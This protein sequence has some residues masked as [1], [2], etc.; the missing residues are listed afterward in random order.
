MARN[1]ASANGPEPLSV[2]QLWQVPVFLL[3][4]VAV[5]AFVMARSLWLDPAAAAA[6]SVLAEA[7]R[8]LHRPNG[9]VDRVVTLAR[10]YLERTGADAPQSGEAHFLIGSALLRTA[11]KANGKEADTCWR[12]VRDHLEEAAQLG[13]SP[14]DQPLLCFR[15]GL[16]GLQTGMDL[17]RVAQLLAGSIEESDEKVEGYRALAH[18][19]LS[20]SP[21]DLG[22]AL[23]ANEELRQLPL[24][25]E[26]ILGPARV[27][28]GDILLRLHRL[29]DARKVLDKVSHTAP[30]SLLAETRVLRAKSY[31]EERNW[32]E[33]APLWREVLAD[34]HSPPT[35]PGPV[36]YQL[37]LCYRRLEQNAD[38][39]RVWRE[40]LQ[41]GPTGTVSSQ[42][43]AVAAALGLADVLLAEADPAA[44]D[45]LERGVHNLRRPED[46]KNSFLCLKKAQA[47]FEH[48]QA[49]YRDK[50]DFEHAV[51]VAELYERLA[52]PAQ[53]ALLLGQGAEGWA[54][55]LRQ[56]GSQEEARAIALFRRA[57]GAYARAADQ[58]KTPREQSE[59]LWL[60]AGA[61]LRAQD[62]ER[63]LPV[64]RRFLD[65]GQHPD[66]TGEAWYLLAEAQRW[67]K[68]AAA[69]EAAYNE[70]VKY[71]GRF[72]HRA[73]YRL[74]QI[75]LQRHPPQVD[76]AV[77]IL[78]QNIR[79]LQRNPDAEAL[80]K[81]LFAL[82]GLLY[83]RHDYQTAQKL[84]EDAVTQFPNSPQVQRGR[85]ELAECW[86]NLAA[87]LNETLGGSMS[88]EARQHYEK[89]QRDWLERAAKQY[90]LLG[91][92]LSA[93]KV[94]TP[95]EQVQALFSIAECRFN[96]G[97]YDAARQLYDQLA[98]RFKGRAEQLN[99]LGGSV[100]CYAAQNQ[101]EKLA[102]RLQ[103]I[104]LVLK[105]ADE[106][107]RHRWEEWLKL[108][109][110]H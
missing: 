84:L 89:Q 54:Q 23:K 2:R 39:A 32:A 8:I 3:G 87:Q 77:E 64:L 30:A 68:N 98:E 86:R 20:L 14:K 59:R 101:A 35:E 81:S 41:R 34:R 36:L 82:G 55:A 26:D 58:A 74:S 18:A 97:E 6:R 63:A 40:C 78:D 29:A 91:T 15:L 9:D 1:S 43:A 4:I 48:G 49:V 60:S 25:G 70:C 16:A 67:L 108:A 50:G 5:G 99:A 31:Q 13:V 72:G 76:R 12:Q 38:A 83:R 46:W 65:L 28:A 22:A 56:R 21:P 61:Y 96:L 85:F 94:L 80:E 7:R 73:R 17:H 71:P 90:A 88:P 100:R 33:A 42:E 37:G 79:A 44:V 107:T 95:Q 53:V 19:Y 47:I 51:R 92:A 106:E 11:R 69:A 57:G 102:Q 93:P 10:T 62:A 104:R 66:F 24:L 75:E 27:Q 105:E 45:L 103:E 110:R 109:G 52:P